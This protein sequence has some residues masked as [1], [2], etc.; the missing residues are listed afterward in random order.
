MIQRI[1]SI[2]LLLAAAMFGGTYALPFARANAAPD[3]ALPATNAFA[4]QVLT[5]ADNQLSTGCL[6]GAALFCIVAIFRYQHRLRQMTTAWVAILGACIGMAM[7]I[8]EYLQDKG[9]LEVGLDLGG[10]AALGGTLCTL[11]AIKSIRK[12]EHIVKSMDRLR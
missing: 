2:Y 8:W 3:T 12:D 6:I 10:L 1:Q 5:L 11:L 4:D 9:T 7:L